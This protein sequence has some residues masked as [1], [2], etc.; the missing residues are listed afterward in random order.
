MA[1]KF[2]IIINTF[3]KGHL[4]CQEPL[5]EEKLN[6]KKLAE[7][8]EAATLKS[9]MDTCSVLYAISPALHGLATRAGDTRHAT[10]VP[11]LDFACSWFSG[12][13]IVA[14]EFTK[15][16]KRK[17][18]KPTGVPHLD[19]EGIPVYASCGI[20]FSRDPSKIHSLNILVMRPLETDLETAAV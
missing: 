13:L 4:R 6:S 8:F 17:N 10:V 5:A 9:G 1:Q 7:L 11:I 15:H 16:A 19:I 20:F 2:S 12:Q 18:G 14:H 3:P